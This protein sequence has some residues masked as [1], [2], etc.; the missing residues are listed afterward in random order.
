MSIR[1]ARNTRRSGQPRRRPRTGATDPKRDAIAVKLHMLTRKSWGGVEPTLTPGAQS[2]RQPFA[3]L[4]AAV[5]PRDA[6]PPRV[7]ARLPL[8]GGHV[9]WVLRFLRPGGGR[10]ESRRTC[11]DRGTSQRIRIRYVFSPLTPKSGPV[12]PTTAP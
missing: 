7:R 9:P 3:G 6:A 11:K 5:K 1:G 8:A 4:Y 10:A 12:S 2:G